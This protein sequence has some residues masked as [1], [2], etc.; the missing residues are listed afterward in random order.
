MFCGV[1]PIFRLI[2]SYVFQQHDK[3]VFH[4]GKARISWTLSKWTRASVSISMPFFLPHA[5]G[6]LRAETEIS[7]SPKSGSHTS[8]FRTQGSF[9][10]LKQFPRPSLNP[11]CPKRN[12]SF[13]HP[14]P[15]RH[16]DSSLRSGTYLINSLC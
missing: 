2:I 9:V 3:S 4:K 12:A 8:G 11:E 13:N 15:S 10:Y 1:C 16:T 7:H 14:N 6:T 5:E